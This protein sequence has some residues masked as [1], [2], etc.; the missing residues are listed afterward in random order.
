MLVSLLFCL[1]TVSS[2]YTSLVIPRTF[3]FRDVSLRI[4][5]VGTLVGALVG[6]G[7]MSC[8]V[9]CLVMCFSKSAKALCVSEIAYKNWLCCTPP[10]SFLGLLTELIYL[11]AEW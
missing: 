6:F 3:S 5:T 4:K 9:A 7:S 8:L 10:H 2:V 11:H 1:F